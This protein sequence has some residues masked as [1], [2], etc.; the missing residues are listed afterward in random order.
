MAP[1]AQHAAGGDWDGVNVVNGAIVALAKGKGKG[2][3]TA[4][5]DSKSKGTSLKSAVKGGGLV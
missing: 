1:P 5:G 4:K 2:K 3:G